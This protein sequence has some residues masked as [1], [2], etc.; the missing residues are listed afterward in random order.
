MEKAGIVKPGGTAGAAACHAGHVGD[1]LVGIVTH[2]QMRKVVGPDG[3]G[4]EQVGA[5]HTSDR[6]PE[7]AA[8]ATGIHR[9][10]ATQ[11]RA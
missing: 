1:G 9:S 10:C 2:V 4:P 8:W 7:V 5:K 11:A 6:L 3:P